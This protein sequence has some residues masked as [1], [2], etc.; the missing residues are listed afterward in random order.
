MNL[1]LND[2][3]NR[4][5]STDLR[6][7]GFECLDISGA[8]GKRP[9]ISFV[10]GGQKTVIEAKTL[11]NPEINI[12]IS[13]TEKIAE[14][15]ENFRGKNREIRKKINQK[16]SEIRGVKLTFDETILCLS[17][18]LGNKYNDLEKEDLTSRILNAVYN[19]AKYMRKRNAEFG[20]ITLDV[21]KYIK[22]K[23]NN[24]NK[25]KRNLYNR[26]EI[27]D[28]DDIYTNGA[29]FLQHSIKTEEYIKSGE[30]KLNISLQ[31]TDSISETLFACSVL[32]STFLSSTSHIKDTI[33][34]AEKKLETYNNDYKKILFFNNNFYRL[35]TGINDGYEELIREIRNNV[36]ESI[37]DEV[38]IEY[39]EAFT[40]LNYCDYIES[41]SEDRKGYERIY[42]V[43]EPK[44][45][46]F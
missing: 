46:F 38:W 6:D 39:T 22:L 45:R 15:I 23:F 35:M 28:F 44:Q 8:D 37:I 20:S 18:I 40:E 21:S 34:S 16:K 24:L 14:L 33:R 25:V 27:S 13:F 12:T 5:Y 17:A 10:F 3:I 31:L 26:P 29:E 2:F 41:V 19:E 32:S 30:K 4:V 43:E 36:K 7:I 11:V 1:F 42:P 9:E